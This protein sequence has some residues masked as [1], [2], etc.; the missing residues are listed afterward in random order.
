MP[1]A[2]GRSPEAGPSR[3]RTHTLVL[4]PDVGSGGDHLSIFFWSLSPPRA[5][6][7]LLSPFMNPAETLSLTL[8][9][10]SNS[11]AAVY[12][13]FA[14][15]FV[16]PVTSCSSLKA[17]ALVYAPFPICFTL[18]VTSCSS[19]YAFALF[20]ADTAAPP[21]LRAASPTSSDRVAAYAHPP[22]ATTAA[23]VPSI[24]PAAT[25]PTIA[26]PAITVAPPAVVTPWRPCCTADTAAVAA[27]G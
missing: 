4:A 15:A 3:V 16:F 14:A 7:S 27:S 2:L 19:L 11:V 8:Y 13:C 17:L 18:P 5:S 22:A 9:F 20:P 25:P 24:A 23:V 26:A 6:E 21:T 12:A 10:S 1:R